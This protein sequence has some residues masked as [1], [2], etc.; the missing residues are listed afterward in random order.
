MN[1][2]IEFQMEEIPARMQPNA[3]RELRRFFESFCIENQI[4]S[5]DLTINST[6]R[7]LTLECSNLP[8]Q[9]ANQTLERKGPKIDAPQAALDEFFHSCGTTPDECDQITTNKGTFWLARTTLAGKPIETLILEFIENTLKTFPWPKSMR[10]SNFPFKWVRPLHNILIILDN[11]PLEGNVLGIPLVS[12]TLGHRFL[13]EKLSPALASPKDYHAFLNDN[14][15]ILERSKRK[16]II[17]TQLQNIETKTQ[18]Q[19]IQDPQLLDEVVGLVEYPLT[20]SGKI[21]P[22]FMELPKELIISV[23]KTHQ[24]YFSF[25]NSSGQLAPVFAVTANNLTP[26]SKP[27][28]VIHGNEKVLRAR[29]SDGQFYWES[30]RKTSLD[31]LSEKLSNII[32]HQKLGTLKDKRDRITHIARL[33]NQWLGLPQDLLKNATTYCKTDLVSG[34][35]G[36]FP[37]LQ[38][39]MGGY[40]TTLQGHPEVSD[41]ITDHY[42]PLGP[43]DSLPRDLL[44]LTVALS[45]KLD[46][47]VNFFAIE[48][49]PTG[50]KDPFALR[51]S[52]LGIIRLIFAAYSEYGKEL[53]I[54]T[55]SLIELILKENKLAININFDLSKTAENITLFL[56]E[57]LKVSLRDGGVHPDIIESVLSS[58]SEDTFITIQKKITAL[59]I[60]LK[61]T[62]SQDFLEAYNRLWK[63]LK[64][65]K[66]YPEELEI[67]PELLQETEEQELYKEWQKR[68]IETLILSRKYEQALISF[69]EMKPF[70]DK[71]FNK[72][73]VNV[74]DDNLRKNRL[75]L[76]TLVLQSI[77]SFA[78][79]EKIAQDK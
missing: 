17:L 23:Q 52:A 49:A 31:L 53:D 67:D 39:I 48:E 71:F 10:W 30:D 45:D 7:R 51:R 50:S 62:N 19:W 6:P 69:T 47:L 35:V 41:A 75:T 13:G 43:N 28:T 33:I 63:L 15:V 3:E 73:L 20:L 14:Y 78:A 36:E 4:S 29:L 40:Y 12:T 61:Q 44:G 34:V 24:R 46:T 37:E 18:T 79:I 16:E 65:Q 11:K 22:E 8:E 54:S 42:K 66:L 55:L 76:I 2:L 9:Q 70:I 26:E 27:K 25:Q 77:K 21:D 56:T 32:F 68:S 5:S 59:T 57:R 74:P 58:S 64:S 60:F 38:G 72:I 1:L